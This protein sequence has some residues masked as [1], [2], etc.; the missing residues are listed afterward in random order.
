[1]TKK[2]FLVV[3][4]WQIKSFVSIL[5]ISFRATWE[6]T[7]HYSRHKFSFKTTLNANIF[8]DLCMYIF[9]NFYDNHWDII[10]FNVPGLWL[11][12]FCQT[13]ASFETN[14][15]KIIVQFYSL[16][17]YL[18]FFSFRIFQE[19]QVKCDSVF[20][21]M[22]SISDSAFRVNAKKSTVEEA[23]LPLKNVGF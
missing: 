14:V 17:L 4:I 20:D 13:L 19:L 10:N 23:V 21:K 1:M 8:M 5:R 2:Q 9:L 12:Q 16:N 15:S 22:H 3:Q 7:L 6:Y 11:C 18:L